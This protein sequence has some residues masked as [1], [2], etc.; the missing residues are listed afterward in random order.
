MLILHNLKIV[1]PFY[2]VE[3]WIKQCVES[4]KSQNYKNFSCILIDD[5]S[6]DNSYEKCVDAVGEDEKFII[7]RN[8]EKKYALKNIIDGINLLKPSDEDVII[9]V[10]GDDWLYNNTVFDKVN[11][12]Y[13]KT[14]CLIT[15]GNYI[16]FPDNRMGHCN[17]YSD[18]T[19]QNNSY[20]Q[21]GWLASHLRTYKY[22]LWKNIKESDFLD[23]QG[24]Y[25]EV[26]CD[27]AIM[28]P[29]LEMAGPRQ[30]FIN[31]PLYVYNMS[32]P[33]ND[34]KKI[35]EKQRHCDRF[36]RSKEKYE[37]LKGKNDN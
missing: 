22:K 11:E 2:N 33:N 36:I 20:R 10:D 16:R 19:I 31:S 18:N 25:L 7:I 15:Y 17:K 23:D 9:N 28:F 24:K 6:T 14:N 8:R 1:V 35:P 5:M 4:I 30:E 27:L 12:V 34:F 3:N 26:A 13:N 37:Q 32:N 21:S 29:M